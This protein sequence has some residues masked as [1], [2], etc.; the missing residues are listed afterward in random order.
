MIEEDINYQNNKTFDIGFAFAEMLC[1][2]II[3]ICIFCTGV[4][5]N[6]VRDQV[7]GILII[8][9]FWSVMPVIMKLIKYKHEFK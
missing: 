6:I 1:R 5:E 8:F 9:V 3:W 7:T 4:F 2:F